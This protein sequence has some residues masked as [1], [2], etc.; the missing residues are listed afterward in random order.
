M[1]MMVVRC[2]DELER[3]TLSKG[4]EEFIHNN[5]LSADTTFKIQYSTYILNNT[6]HYTALVEVWEDMQ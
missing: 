4:I 5:C 6:V 1:E 2:F 3:A